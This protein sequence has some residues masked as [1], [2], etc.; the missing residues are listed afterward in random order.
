M[1][2]ILR[3]W[4]ILLVVL[5]GSSAVYFGYTKVASPLLAG[6]EE[7]KGAVV[8]KAD[9]AALLE[10]A[11]KT[12]DELAQKAGTEELGELATVVGEKADK[13]AVEA[14]ATAMDDKA[15]KIAVANYADKVTKGELNAVKTELAKATEKAVTDERLLRFQAQIDMEKQLRLAKAEARKARRLAEALKAEAVA[16]AAQVAPPESAPAPA[17]P[18]Q[19]RITVRWDPAPAQ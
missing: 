1:R 14:L 13:T 15:D 2:G 9:Q 17:A 11:A 7:L 10:L 3:Y 19:E 5:V 18:A 12:Q 16:A 6:V 8:G 4:W